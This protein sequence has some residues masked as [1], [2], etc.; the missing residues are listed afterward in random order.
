MM[1]VPVFRKPGTKIVWCHMNIRA[2]R[3]CEYRLAA[4]FEKTG[5]FVKRVRWFR[6]MLQNL[7]AKYGIETLIWCWNLRDIADKIN[8]RSTPTLGLQPFIRVP[9]APW[10]SQKPCDTYWR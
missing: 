5:K 9:P 8:S 1:L 2:K 10:H 7:T 6:Y 3:C 4:R